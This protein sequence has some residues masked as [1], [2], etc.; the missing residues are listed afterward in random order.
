MSSISFAVNSFSVN[1]VGLVDWVNASDGSS[2]FPASLVWSFDLP[3][4][5]FKFEVFHDVP[6][7]DIFFRLNLFDFFFILK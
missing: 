2:I 6:I 7:F 1:C 3:L 4:L 5:Y